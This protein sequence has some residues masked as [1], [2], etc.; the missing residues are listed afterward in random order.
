MIF[1]YNTYMYYNWFPEQQR[2][3]L[4]SDLRL[5]Q[6]LFWRKSMTLKIQHYLHSTIKVNI[7]QQQWL[8]PSL[9][10]QQL[11][12]L[13]NQQKCLI[14]EVEL[15]ANDHV[16][17][18]ARSVMPRGR[19]TCQYQYL[20]G[21]KHK[22]IGRWFFSDTNLQR[23]TFNFKCF[24]KHDDLYG[25]AEK[26]IKNLPEMVWGRCSSFTTTHQQLL[27]TELFLPELL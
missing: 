2:W 19:L 12:Q 22:T 27:L 4:P 23:S 14:R 9:D 26:S 16:V 13:P 21:L 1:E 25:Y 7:I 24:T 8:R 3:R 20:P 11:L 17:M 6:W 10:E 18:I 15:C 5:H